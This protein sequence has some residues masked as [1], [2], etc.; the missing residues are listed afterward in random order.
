MS[1]YR[2]ICIHPQL[3][4][5]RWSSFF[6]E[7]VFDNVNILA[8]CG[9]YLALAPLAFESCSFTIFSAMEYTLPVYTRTFLINI[10]WR[11]LEGYK[12]GKPNIAKI[13]GA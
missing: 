4:L 8:P 13:D 12:A 6:Q 3:D 1:L 11:A 7:I 9:E 10:G 2:T 5:S